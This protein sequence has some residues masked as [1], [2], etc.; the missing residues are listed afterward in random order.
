MDESF[1][2]RCMTVVLPACVV[3]C[4]CTPHGCSALERLE[5]LWAHP[6]TGASCEMPC[7]CVA[8]PLQGSW[9]T[10]NPPATQ[11][12]KRLK[13]QPELGCAAWTFTYFSACLVVC[14]CVAMYLCIPCCP[15]TNSVVKASLKLRLLVFP[16]PRPRPPQ[17]AE[18]KGVLYHVQLNP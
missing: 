12:S 11:S 2:F 3:L 9:W 10:L 17:H 5:E 1:Y 15:G 6:G 13:W 4:I 14:L 8:G 18:I 7:G 16:R